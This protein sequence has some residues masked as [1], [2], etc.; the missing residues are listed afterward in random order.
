MAMRKFSVGWEE[1]RI[2]DW[3]QIYRRLEADRGDSLGW[4]GLESWVG[5]WA[6]RKLPEMAPE[7]L[8]DLVADTCASVVVGFA[9]A[10]GAETFFGFAYGHFLNVRGRLLRRHRRVGLPLEGVEIAELPEE[11]PAPDE[12][13]LLRRCLETLPPRERRAIELRYFENAHAAEI[14][15]LLGVTPVNARRLVFNALARLRACV[16]QTWPEGRA[17]APAPSRRQPIQPFP[18]AGP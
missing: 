18:A 1:D 7:E 5:L 16:R 9:Q 17:G 13:T 11:G 4:L 10:R 3:G 8:E 12:L 15:R 14:G 6:R 2:L